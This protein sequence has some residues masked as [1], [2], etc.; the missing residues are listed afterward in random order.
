VRTQR[1]RFARLYVNGRYYQYTMEVEDIDEDLL[2]KTGGPGATVGD[3]FKSDGAV[4]DNQGPWG[5]GNFRPLAPNASCPTRWSKL[6]RYRTTYERQTHEW[7]AADPSGH[8]ELIQMIEALPPLYEAAK[9]SGDWTAVRAFLEQRFDVPQ[10][11]SLYAVRNFAGA[12]DDGSH[13]YYLYKR[14]EDGK[15]QVLPQD[16]DLEFGGYGRSPSASIFIG[17]EGAGEDPVGGVNWLK[18]A[19]I[20]AFRAELRARFAELLGTVLAEKNVVDQLNQALASWDPGSWQEAPA[21]GKC[22]AN[23]RVNA[24]RTWLTARY[25]HLA[26]LGLR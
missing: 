7:K 12:W 13:N 16:F 22:D 23:A 21:L 11:L 25:A 9:I 14:P 17:E 24:A 6:D 5:K 8:Q 15:Y 4:D 1:F 3:L 26:T 19:V 2:G 20:K 18:S 10:L